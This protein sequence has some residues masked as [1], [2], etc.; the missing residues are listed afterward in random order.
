MP[1]IIG[2]VQLINKTDFCY[3]TNSQLSQADILKQGSPVCGRGF[4]WQPLRE[5]LL[6]VDHDATAGDGSYGISRVC[7]V[8]RPNLVIV[9]EASGNF[10]PYLDAG[11]LGESS[12]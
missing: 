2:M 4:P 1:A 5:P 10:I 8:R 3:I 12:V 11:Y 6:L 7:G 9:D